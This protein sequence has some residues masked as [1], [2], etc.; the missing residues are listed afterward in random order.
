[1]IVLQIL[2]V[3]GVALLL[4]IGTFVIGSSG[5]EQ[6]TYPTQV[7]QAIIAEPD[8]ILTDT[9]QTVQ[10]RSYREKTLDEVTV[11]GNPEPEFLYQPTR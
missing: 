5:L 4:L 2:I 3:P 10:S 1:M 11:D 7:D 6:H 9:Q 8:L